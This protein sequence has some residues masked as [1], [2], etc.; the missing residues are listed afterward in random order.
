MD[1][2]NLIK[3]LHP[4]EV[5]VLLAYGPDDE[6]DSDRLK[7]DLGYR[8]GQDNQAFSWLVAKEL[9]A[10]S[11]RT[12]RTIYEITQLGRDTERDGTPEER[13][14]AHL[15]AS[16]ASRIPDIVQGLGL[17]QK[18][19]GSAFG[20]LAKEGLLVMDAEKKASLAP[21][22]SLPARVRVLKELLSSAAR[23][24]DGIL[25]EAALDA[26]QLG[27]MST[28]AKKAWRSGCL[29]PVGGAGTRV[30]PS[31]SRIPAGEG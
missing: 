21:G 29:L 12:A 14:L 16:G 13:I 11:S 30:L 28:I 31:A 8:D 19:V 1:A 6:L 20:Q 24:A 18:T 27:V 17:D 2:H 26:A 22:V 10:V 3:T 7:R 5:K 4:L 15:S 25:E 23:A 9:A